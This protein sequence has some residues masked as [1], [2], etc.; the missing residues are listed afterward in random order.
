MKDYIH[1]LNA[2]L[3]GDPAE[4]TFRPALEALFKRLGKNI[5]PFNDPR[6]IGDIGAPDFT[7][8]RR[9]RKTLM[10][11]IGYV[12][13]KD[14]GK[15]LDHALKTPQLQRYL[16]LPNLVLTDYL[17]FRR[18]KDRKEE[19]RARLGHV[20]KNRV[21]LAA[22]GEEAVR[23]LLELFLA[24][25]PG[26]ITKPHE[27]ASSMARY[28][29]QIR[30]MIIVRFPAGQA[31]ELL[32]GL[33]S[34]FE[35]ALL[36]DLSVEQFADMFAQ[37]L[38]YGLFAARV[39]HHEMG[40]T[41]DFQRLGAAHEIP[42][43]NPFLRDLFETI[44]GT[45]LDEEPFVGY[46]DDLVSLL[47]LADIGEIMKYFCHPSRQVDPIVHFYESFLAEY[48]PAERRLRGVYY[49]PM[50][51]V[52]YIVRSIDHLLKEKFGLE[53]GL[54]DCS[55]V[56]VETTEGGKAVT[57][58][59]PKVLILDPACGTGTFLYAI[60]D[61]IR[62]KFIDENNAGKWPG[63]IERHLLPRIFG[64]ELLVAPYAVAHLKLG[65]QLAGFDLDPLMRAKF[66]VDPDKLDLPDGRL[67][68]YLTNSLEMTERQLQQ[69]LGFLFDRRLA[70]EAYGAY[71]VK[72]EWPIMVVLG[73]PPYAGH[74][75]NRS[76]YVEEIPPGGEYYKGDKKR[77]A[78]QKGL[79]V[80]RRTFIGNLLQS[81]Y[82]VD[83]HRLEEKNTKWLQDDYVK[84]I[85]FGQ[86]RIEKTKAGILALITNHG[87]LDNPTF[88]GMRQSL[89]TSF[90]ELYLL[91]LHGN[92]KKKETAPDGGK[93]E[94]VFD[95]QQGVG[96]G[97]FVKKSEKPKKPKVHKA[98]LYGRREV[99][100]G[101]YGWLQANDVTTTEW[102]ELKPAKPFYLFTLRDALRATEWEDGW[103]VN[104][105]F[106]LNSVGIVTARDELTIGWTRKE[107]IDRVKDFVSLD[108]EQ[109]REKY[110]LGPD[111]EDWKVKWAQ[112]DVAM[113]SAIQDFVEPILY[114]PFDTRYIYFTGTSRGFICR[115]RTDVMQHM[116]ATGNVSLITAR[117]NKSMWRDHFFVSRVMTE[118]K[119]GESTTQSCLFPL[120]RIESA[121]G[122]V[123]CPNVALGFIERVSRTLRLSFVENG[124]GD[125]MKTFGPEDAFD[126]I[127]AVF[128]CPTYR[129][130]YAEFLKM[131]FPR[132]PLTSNVELFRRLVKLGGELVS[133]HLL[134]SPRLAKPTTRYPE[135]G[136]G[137]VE[138]V[139]YE[140]NNR[141]V[142][143]N[144]KQYFE[145]V[146]PEVW[147][148]HIGGYQVA[149]KWLKDRKGR[150]LELAD[151]E[152][153]E[154]IIVALSET[155][156]LMKEID[157]AIPKWPI[158]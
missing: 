121:K 82:Q 79:K 36:P 2:K 127:Y 9:I 141:R 27:L 155:I 151:I 97:I 113:H 75:A 7:I 29:D 81:Y 130:R 18:Y 13:T 136:T 15:D 157:A 116:L 90:D 11:A 55:T 52:S 111:V 139:Q 105:I 5:E 28:C 91:D 6:H 103:R 133:L 40:R 84:F 8:R 76:E 147:E 109:S 46:V 57:K 3:T 140:E 93:D 61:H 96:I 20:I 71:R 33:K 62:Q 99:G 32:R 115:P 14:I 49:T 51:V 21:K 104:D 37:T 108:A 39:H 132:V 118:A 59:I 86:W 56:E 124:H 88:R 158:E 143:I 87:Y 24:Q 92:A 89:L 119:T 138:V 68:I 128:H 65:M 146:P 145:G 117:S 23:S 154:K 126:Y 152:H 26:P 98:D 72:T 94:N 41:D 156:R 10:P 66:G 149:E 110:K 144:A 44:T 131:D 17:E 148:F 22:G 83:G 12:E 47:A 42:K 100:G 63:Y 129:T 74:S 107:I 53:D 45:R 125:M 25:E 34:A 150:R 1:D 77:R 58:P 134:E 123:R 70:E 122:T 67:N 54:A 153:Y 19:G 142:R 69:H 64:F 30:D 48:N 43:T 80:K 101:K 50:P 60:V 38:A 73:N 106:P 35:H 120:Y 114:R 137:T 31:S 112:E 102:A 95:I 85:R 16:D 4:H 78:G 135:Q